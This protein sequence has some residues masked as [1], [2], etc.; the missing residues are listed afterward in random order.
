ME[1]LALSGQI[2]QMADRHF[3]GSTHFVLDVKVNNRMNP[4]KITVVVDG[5]TGITIDD[6]AHL[7]RALSDSIHQ[8][9]LLDDYNL[10]VTTPGIDQPLKWLRQ[11]QKHIGRTLK[12]E[13]KENK[14]VRGKLHQIEEDGIIIEAEG[15]DK[16]IMK[17]D[18]NQISKTFVMVSFK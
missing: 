10:E 3:T 12:V 16:S 8:A 14:V 17:I 18:F 15:K 13:M 2:K 6:C 7:S 4:P 1:N 5:D 11:Y 9:N